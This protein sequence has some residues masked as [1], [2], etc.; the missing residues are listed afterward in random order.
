MTALGPGRVK[1]PMREVDTSFLKKRILQLAAPVRVG[2]CTL[3]RKVRW[4][5]GLQD[6]IGVASRAPIGIAKGDQA[7]AGEEQASTLQRAHAS[8]LDLA[9]KLTRGGR[10][11]RSGR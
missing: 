9:H 1:T 8:W 3:H 4:L 6:A 7:A 10:C 11:S 2:S 5:L